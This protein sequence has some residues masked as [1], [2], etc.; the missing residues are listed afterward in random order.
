MYY[1][2]LCYLFVTCLLVI[3]YSA[4]D[5]GA[6]FY[7]TPMHEVSQYPVYLGLSPLGEIVVTYTGK[8]S[9][10]RPDD[11]ITHSD[12]VKILSGSLA[13]FLASGDREAI[14]PIVDDE[15]NKFGG[16]KLLGFVMIQSILPR[17]LQSRRGE[18]AYDMEEG[19]PAPEIQVGN[20]II[21]GGSV[22]TTDGDDYKPPPNGGGKCITG[23]DCY[24]GNGTCSSYGCQCIGDYTGSYCQVGVYMCVCVCSVLEYVYILMFI[25]IFSIYP[26][27]CAHLHDTP[28]TPNP[29]PNTPYLIA[30]SSPNWYP[31][32]DEE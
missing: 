5:I 21:G 2:I 6:K 20:V 14:L 22:K 25:D 24:Y 26:F 31:V 32:E 17:K 16:S 23:R 27:F 29:I 12:D 1:F 19:G 8:G 30:I 18:I 7:N 4:Q 9:D 3:C 11:Y 13:S 15:D 10:L 28:N